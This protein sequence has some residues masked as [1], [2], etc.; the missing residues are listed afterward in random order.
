[1]NLIKVPG[2][3]PLLLAVQT[4]ET[5]VYQHPDESILLEKVHEDAVEMI[6]TITTTKPVNDED[7]IL[8]S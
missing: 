1:M 8:F 2:S 5:V 3:H 6:A 7:L 4:V